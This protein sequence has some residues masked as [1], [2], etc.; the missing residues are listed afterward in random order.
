MKTI[1]FLALL[2]LSQLAVAGDARILGKWQEDAVRSLAFI[3]QHTKLDAEEFSFLKQMLGRTTFVITDKTFT[4]SMSAWDAEFRGAKRHVHAV[5]EVRFYEIVSSNDKEL[6]IKLFDT[7]TKREAID[8]YQFE[9]PDVIWT[10]EP[11]FH[12]RQYY[13]RVP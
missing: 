10:Y 8:V 3:E 7:M 13:V 12:T 6:V 5:N 9:G 11:R 4:F 1:V 2:A